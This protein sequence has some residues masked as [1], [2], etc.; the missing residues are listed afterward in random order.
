MEVDSSELTNFVKSIMKGFDDALSGS[1]HDL[2][3]PLKVE[4]AITITKDAS[5][6]LTLFPVE[7]G[8]KHQKEEISRITFSIL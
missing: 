4:L 8:G 1:G 3:E 5:G 7:V 6:K 2:T